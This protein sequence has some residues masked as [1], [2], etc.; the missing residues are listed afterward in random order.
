MSDEKTSQASSFTVKISS[1]TENEKSYISVTAA[2][3][4]SK[5]L[6]TYSEAL[7]QRSA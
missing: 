3:E 7:S 1:L 4:I 2:E 5:L 6:Q